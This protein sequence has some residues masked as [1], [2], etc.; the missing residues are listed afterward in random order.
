MKGEP[1]QEENA[2]DFQWTSK[3]NEKAE[4][5]EEETE[6]QEA[7]AEEAVAERR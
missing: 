4:E 3:T 5:E 2:N 7:P 1:T 6:T